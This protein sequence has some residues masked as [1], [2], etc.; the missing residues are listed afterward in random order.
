[1]SSIPKCQAA[2]STLRHAAGRSAPTA[3]EVRRTTCPRLY[4][5]ICARST[6][7]CPGPSSL[8]GSRQL[9]SR[10]GLTKS[11]SQ[12]PLPA[13]AHEERPNSTNRRRSARYRLHIWQHRHVEAHSKVWLQHSALALHDCRHVRP[14]AAHGRS[15][16][17]RFRHPSHAPSRAAGIARRPVPNRN[18]REPAHAAGRRLQT[19]PS[20]RGVG[21]AAGLP[22]AA[23][24][25]VSA[26]SQ[27]RNALASG[28]SPEPGAIARK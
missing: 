7:P 12:Q 28:F 18:G 5:R 1:M 27:S 25:R 14:P 9:A 3:H 13:R 19:L 10:P 15:R 26:R 17:P 11:P 23:L 6:T 16:L 8:A 22:P 21:S 4:H 2:A 20:L 24:F